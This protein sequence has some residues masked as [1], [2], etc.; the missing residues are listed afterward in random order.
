MQPQQTQDRPIRLVGRM[1]RQE[2]IR[3]SYVVQSS[4]GKT[5]MVF[6]HEE[7]ALLFVEDRKRH[8]IT[9]CLMR[10]T[11]IREMMWP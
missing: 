6:D 1:R 5:I 7:S 4:K 3:T 9:A 11:V 8:G 10:E 2:N